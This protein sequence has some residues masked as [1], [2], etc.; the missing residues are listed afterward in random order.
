MFNPLGGIII[1]ISSIIHFKPSLNYYNLLCKMAVALERP[2]LMKV[3]VN[4]VAV[5]GMSPGDVIGGKTIGGPVSD[6][7]L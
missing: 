5:G 1:F 3:S 4:G 6:K 2:V 7:L